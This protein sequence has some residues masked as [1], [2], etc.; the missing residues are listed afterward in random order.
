MIRSATAGD[1]GMTFPPQDN[2]RLPQVEQVSQCHRFNL[3][4]DG[5]S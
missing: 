3:S 5:D 4:M 1:V 2:M